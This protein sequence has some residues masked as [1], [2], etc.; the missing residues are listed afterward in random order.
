MG[1]Y[2]MDSARW[3]TC[4]GA[5]PN[6]P[7]YPTTGV[8]G[9]TSTAASSELVSAKSCVVYGVMLYATANGN[10]ILSNAAGTALTGHTIPVLVTTV[11]PQF[12]QVGGAEGLLVAGAGGFSASGDQAGINF[13]VYYSRND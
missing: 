11:I 7:L 12:I 13:D 4:V 6:V 9:S 8:G 3:L 1:S 2:R 5:T 10:V